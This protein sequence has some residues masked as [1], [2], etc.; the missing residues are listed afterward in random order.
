MEVTYKDIQLAFQSI[1]SLSNKSGQKA[2]VI[3]WLANKY[4]QL[5]P[6]YLDMEKQRVALL[7]RY[8]EM[9]NPDVAGYSF[10][11]PEGRNAFDEEYNDLLESGV[12]LDIKPTPLQKLLD[13]GL[14]LT[15]VELINLSWMI[16][17]GD[18]YTDPR[19]N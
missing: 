15:A 18:D 14:E 9:T 1:R 6:H 5:E 8:G 16:E 12:I 11:T 13:G 2:S 19:P 7:K 4:R 17:Y 3:V 10:T